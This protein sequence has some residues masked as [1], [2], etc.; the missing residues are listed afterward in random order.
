MRRLYA[1]QAACSWNPSC[2]DWNMPWPPPIHKDSTHDA[3]RHGCYLGCHARML[4]V[5]PLLP[6]DGRKLSPVCSGLSQFALVCPIYIQ[7]QNRRNSMG[8]NLGHGFRGGA[9]RLRGSWRPEEAP[10]VILRTGKPMSYQ[11]VWRIEAPPVRRLDARVGAGRCSAPPATPSASC[12]A[13]SG[14]SS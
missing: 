6:L 9:G 2:G 5:V 14:S 1:R 4:H 3:V 8:S 12:G 7:S 10:R 11:G 13:S